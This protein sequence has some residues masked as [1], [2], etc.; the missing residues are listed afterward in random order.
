MWRNGGALL[1]ILLCS[2]LSNVACRK[3][4]PVYNPTRWMHEME[5]I[6]YDKS[7]LDITL[8]GTHDSGA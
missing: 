2:A 8:P 6:I 7:L 3:P 4:A 1:M 5:H